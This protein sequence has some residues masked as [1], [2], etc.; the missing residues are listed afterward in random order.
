[1]VL[2]LLDLQGDPVC[3]C[4]WEGGG[5]GRGGLGVGE[6]GMRQARKNNITTCNNT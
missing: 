3:V 6:R 2:G 1:M 4:V 5:G